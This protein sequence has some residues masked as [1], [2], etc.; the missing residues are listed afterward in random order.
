[1]NKYFYF[2]FARNLIGVSPS[3]RLVAD[4]RYAVDWIK[5]VYNDAIDHWSE[6]DDPEDYVKIHISGSARSVTFTTTLSNLQM[7]AL[8]CKV[9]DCDFDTTNSDK[10]AIQTAK[11]DLVDCWIQRVAQADRLALV[12][13]FTNCFA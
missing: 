8:G 13:E 5:S 3:E 7:L 2:E 12:K 4:A 11:K 10:E 6:G 9:L 1:M